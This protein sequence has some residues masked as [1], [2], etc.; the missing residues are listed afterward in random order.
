MKFTAQ[1]IIKNLK[2]EPHPE[3]GYYR[4]IYRSTQV[5]P[6]DSWIPRRSSPRVSAT[7]IYF[8]LNKSQVSKWHRLKSDELWFYHSGNPILIHTFNHQGEYHAVHLG[9]DLLQGQRPQVLIPA[10][11]IFG[12]EL[13]DKQ[14][15]SLIGCLVSPG[16][17]FSD[18]ELVSPNQIEKINSELS[19]LIRRLG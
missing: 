17:E 5:I 6:G 14:S 19:P 18:F 1:E 15:Y 11:T 10:G 8:L 7:S 4:E 3:G 2:L 9:M 16:F 13:M 12:A